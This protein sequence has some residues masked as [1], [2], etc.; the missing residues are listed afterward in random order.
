M[1][2]RISMLVWI[3]SPSRRSATWRSRTGSEGRCVVMRKMAAQ[4]P[5]VFACGSIS[6]ILKSA[7]PYWPVLSHI[8]F[9]PL[10]REGRIDESG[11]TV[12]PG[13]DHA[14]A[15]SREHLRWGFGTN[16]RI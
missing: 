3:A 9:P 11:A 12:D 7:S 16:R 13:R 4:D 8:H 10:K 14:P 2:W 1:A 5:G 15:D 6:T